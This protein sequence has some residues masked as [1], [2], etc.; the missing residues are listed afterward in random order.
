MSA[1]RYAIPPFTTPVRN[2]RRFLHCVACGTIKKERSYAL[3]SECYRVNGSLDRGLFTCLARHA[4]RET[5][6]HVFNQS[7]DSG[8]CS[9]Y[10]GF[11]PIS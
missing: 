4:I 7:V 6:E 10:I 8:V 3:C 9:T 5:G 2:D 11:Q 1:T